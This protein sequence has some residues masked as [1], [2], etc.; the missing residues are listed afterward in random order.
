MASNIGF[1]P[2]G[3]VL[4]TQTYRVNGND[5]A[6]VCKW[7]VVGMGIITNIGY[8]TAATAGAST[9]LGCSL[10]FVS[11]AVTGTTL[12]ANDP[13]QTFECRDDDGS[14]KLTDIGLTG[15]HLATTGSVVTRLSAHKFDMDTASIT[16]GGFHIIEYPDSPDEPAID[17]IDKR[18][19]VASTTEHARRVATSL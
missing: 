2:W 17:I 6:P 12:V 3:P 18:L 1:K 5:N 19:I 13:D 7:D 15:D 9:I 8:I 10:T 14:S 16:A 4:S 11:G